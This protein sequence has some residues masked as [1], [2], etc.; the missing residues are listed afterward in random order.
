MT[1]S[2]CWPGSEVNILPDGE[3][4]YEDEL[5]A[6]LDWVVA[7]VHTAFGIGEQA[8]TERVIRAI[9]HPLV[10]AIGHPTGRLIERR[11]P[12]AIDLGA[13]F[14]AAARTGTL[15]EINANPDRRDLSDVNAR[16]AVRAG[17]TIV[18]DSDAHRTRD[19]AEHALGHRDRPARVADEGGRREHAAVAGAGAD[20]QTPPRTLTVCHEAR[21]AEHGEGEKIRGAGEGDADDSIL[22]FVHHG[23]RGHFFCTPTSRRGS[24][25]SRDDAVGGGAV[26]ARALTQPRR[27]SPARG[28]SSA[29]RSAAPRSSATRRGSSERAIGSAAYGPGAGVVTSRQPS[30]SASSWAMP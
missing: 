7:S 19:A 30:A 24:S 4:D 10:D 13:V 21:R 28:S 15:L 1:E 18:I 9:E 26:K 27:R 23:A 29:V 20:A 6:E 11:E 22:N 16:D 12:Y 3:L 25:S 8:M 17:V 2:R 5:L 14:A